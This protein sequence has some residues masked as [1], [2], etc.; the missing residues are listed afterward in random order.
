MEEKLY[1]F[2]FNAISDAIQL[3]EQGAAAQACSLL[4][5]AQQEAEERYISADA[6]S[7]AMKTPLRANEEMK[8]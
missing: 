5:A 4:I 3:L 8:E 7:S 2:L 6:D 1:F